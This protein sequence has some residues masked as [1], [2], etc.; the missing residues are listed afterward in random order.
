[1]GNYH[2]M[3]K[4]RCCPLI[5][6]SNDSKAALFYLQFPQFATVLNHI[7]NPKPCDVAAGI[8]KVLCRHQRCAQNTPATDDVHTAANLCKNRKNIDEIFSTSK[9]ILIIITN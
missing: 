3:L 9:E 5:L 1:M 7:L 4:R 8:S 2:M 6:T